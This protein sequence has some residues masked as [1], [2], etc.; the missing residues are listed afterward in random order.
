MREVRSDGWEAEYRWECVG[1]TDM[2]S[3]RILYTQQQ[4]REKKRRRLLLLVRVVKK[5]Q[6]HGRSPEPNRRIVWYFETCYLPGDHID[7]NV[8]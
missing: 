7:P 6:D 8:L 1:R 4:R 5:Q 3:K 2:S